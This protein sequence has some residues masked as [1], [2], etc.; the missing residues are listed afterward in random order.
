MEHE[1]NELEVC[2]YPSLIALSFQCSGFF[3]RK[4]QC[5][6]KGVLQWCI[7]PG[8]GIGIEHWRN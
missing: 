1:I 5:L 7:V 8:S 2:G 6:R 4:E 3:Y